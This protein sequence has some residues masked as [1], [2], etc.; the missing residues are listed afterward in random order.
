MEYLQ[1]EHC[2]EESENGT[3][4]DRADWLRLFLHVKK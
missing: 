2:I 1:Q 4:V 3:E